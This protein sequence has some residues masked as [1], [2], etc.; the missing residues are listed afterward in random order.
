MTILDCIS[1]YLGTLRFILLLF[2]I[3]ILRKWIVYQLELIHSPVSIDNYLPASYDIKY[4]ICLIPSTFLLN[5]QDT[6]NN[7]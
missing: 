6:A 3:S 2:S 1:A 7:A 5:V 4:G